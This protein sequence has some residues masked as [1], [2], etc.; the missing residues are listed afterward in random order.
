MLSDDGPPGDIATLTELGDR[1]DD[2]VLRRRPPRHRRRCTAATRSTRSGRHRQLAID[3]AEASGM[4]AL[5]NVARRV[6]TSAVAPAAGAGRRASTPEGSVEIAC[7]GGFIVRL[8]GRDAD[9]GGCAR[10]TASCWRCSRRAPACHT[11]ARS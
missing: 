10:S 7:M 3:A 6:G 8:A 4:T 2:P 5:A 11:I 1:R 9:L